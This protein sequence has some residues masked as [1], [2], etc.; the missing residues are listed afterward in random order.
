MFATSLGPSSEGFYQLICGA[1]TGPYIYDATGSKER[2]VP[3]IRKV[4]GCGACIHIHARPIASDD[5]S[6]WSAAVTGVGNKVIP[7]DAQYFPDLVAQ[8]LSNNSCGLGCHI[9]GVGCAVW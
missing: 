5:L 2:I 9:C 4:N 7:L 3:F 1:E 8:T 6:S